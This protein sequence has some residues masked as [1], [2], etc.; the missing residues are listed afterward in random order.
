MQKTYIR[1]SSTGNYILDDS[2]S[3]IIQHDS[4]NLPDSNVQ[5]IMNQGTIFETEFIKIIKNKHTV[6]NITSIDIDQEKKYTE[7]LKLLEEGHDI[8]YQGY[9][10]NEDKTLGGSPDLIVKSTY[11]NTL[12]E[13]NF[14]ENNKLP[15]HYNNK[16][17]L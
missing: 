10:F 4:N 16:P 3:D 13:M 5:F 11:I 8:I 12:M 6:V 14:M 1:A 9:L 17:Y 7:T 2:L 15:I